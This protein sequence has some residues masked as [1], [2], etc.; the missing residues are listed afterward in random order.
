MTIETKASLCTGT[1]MLDSSLPGRLAW[2][3]ETNEAAKLLL[4]REHPD[5]PNLGDITVPDF[6]GTYVDLLTSGDPCQSMSAAG[7]QLA[8]DDER[9]LWWDVERVID[10]VR[11]RHI[12]LENVQNLVSVPL[13]K[14]GE[15]GGVL[16]LRLDSLRERGYAARWTVLGA[17]AVGAPHHRHRWFLRA[18]YV[19]TD[20]TPAAERVINKCGAPRSG[21]RALLPS[22]TRADSTG[23]PGVSP[24]RTGGMNPRTAVTLLPTPVVRDADGRGEGSPDFWSRRAEYRSNGMPLGAAVTLLPTPRAT[25][26]K[27][28]PAQRGR[29]GD[30]GMGLA[31]QA[32]HWGKFAEAIATWE[33]IVGRSVPEPTE[34]APRGGRRLNAALSEWM[35]GMPAG[36]VT[37]DFARND[38]LRLVGNGVV[39]LAARAAWDML[40]P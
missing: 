30:P 31:V 27:G 12:F 13:V 24:K 35:M 8:S 9:F 36:Y 33:N 25:D 39:P 21:G 16:K 32:E 15:R 4:K 6:A 1:G 7:R 34:L 37:R 28:G 20:G 26:Y 22:P 5:V 17:C 18:W 11:P 38:A 14:G 10:R 19:G 23:G 3:A 2:C 40:A 29:R